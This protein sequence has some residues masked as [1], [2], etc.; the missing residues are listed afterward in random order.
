MWHYLVITGG[1]GITQSKAFDT[2]Y[3]CDQGARKAF[4]KLNPDTDSI[5]WAKLKHG[6]LIT[7]EFP[8]GFF[9]KKGEE[10]AD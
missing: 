1:V 4:R 6:Q 8:A 7:G 5:F 3:D 9:E 10:D 2:E